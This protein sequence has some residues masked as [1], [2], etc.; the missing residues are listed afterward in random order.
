MGEDSGD[1]GGP[2]SCKIEISNSCCKAD[3][4]TLGC[5]VVGACWTERSQIVRQGEEDAEALRQ[6]QE[7]E[8][9]YP[10]TYISIF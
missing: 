2:Q 5:Y 3:V 6:W 10:L 1:P 7:A 8:T 9:L 4:G